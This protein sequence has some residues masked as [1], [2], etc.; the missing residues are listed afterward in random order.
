MLNML[1]KMLNMLQKMLL[2]MLKT[3][4]LNSMQILK[5]LALLIIRNIL[6]AILI[7]LMISRLLMILMVLILILNPYPSLIQAGGVDP[8]LFFS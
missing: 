7:S 1:Q 8:P 2:R 3:L 5:T 4:T 6:A